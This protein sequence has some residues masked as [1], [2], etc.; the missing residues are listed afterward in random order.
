MAQR[1]RRH[2]LSGVKPTSLLPSLD[3]CLD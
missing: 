3:P 1:K 2:A